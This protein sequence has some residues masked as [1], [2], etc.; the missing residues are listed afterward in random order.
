MFITIRVRPKAKEESIKKVNCT[1]FRISVKEPPEKNKANER[2][3]SLLAEKF[4]IPTK[5]VLI[6]NP[7]SRIKHVEIRNI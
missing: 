1:E 5:N 3:R 4:N 7:T 2:V 6:K